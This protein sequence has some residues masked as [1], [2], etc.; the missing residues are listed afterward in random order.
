MDVEKI[1]KLTDQ[2]DQQLYHL[3]EGNEPQK[4]TI[5]QATAAIR[6]E[7]PKPPPTGGTFNWSAVDNNK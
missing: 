1:K 6:D 5:R 4:I 3:S 7:L 2:I